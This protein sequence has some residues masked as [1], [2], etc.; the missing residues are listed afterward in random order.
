M[1]KIFHIVALTPLVNSL[2]NRLLPFYKTPRRYIAHLMAVRT[3]GVV[4]V[5]LFMKSS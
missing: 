4:E 3:L 1:A 5:W 2:F